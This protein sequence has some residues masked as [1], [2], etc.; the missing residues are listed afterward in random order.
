MIQ[1]VLAAL[2]S[3]ELQIGQWNIAD[4]C[5][6]RRQYITM[7]RKKKCEKKT[8]TKTKINYKLE[9]VAQMYLGTYLPME[10]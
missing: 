7:T 5:Y 10:W 6:R 1:V 4:S 8:K 9:P 2:D 3:A